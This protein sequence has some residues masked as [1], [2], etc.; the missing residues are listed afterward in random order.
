MKVDFSIVRSFPLKATTVTGFRGRRGGAIDVKHLVAIC[1]RNGVI[2][3]D[4]D[5]PR[6]N[7]VFHARS[8]DANEQRFPFE[9]TPNPF[10]HFRSR[11]SMFELLS[12]TFGDSDDRN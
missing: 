5:G 10:L 1:K 7:R 11:D 8:T 2:P 4:P 6:T 9:Q 12:T 3:K